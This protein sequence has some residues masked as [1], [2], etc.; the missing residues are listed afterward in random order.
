M[1]QQKSRVTFGGVYQKYG[2]WIILAV[3][4]FIFAMLSSNFFQGDNRFFTPDNLLSVGRQVSFIGIAAVGGT[5]LMISGGID[6]STGSMV[7]LAGVLSTMMIVEANM[8][9]ALAIIITVVVGFAFGSVSGIAYTKWKVSPMIATLAMQTILKGISYLITNAKPVRGFGD[10]FKFLGQGYIGGF[11]PVPLAIMIAVF[12]FGWW[13][14]NRTYVGR[15]IYAIG[16]NS[17]AAR[18]S[19]ININKL[20]IIVFA[21]SG[22]FAAFAGV[23][24]AARLGS[25]QPSS[26]ISDF[27]MEVITAV[28]LGGVSIAGGSGKIGSVVA[29]VLIMGIL[30]NGMV[31]LSLSEYWQWVIKGL[32]LM[33]AVA[34]SNLQVGGGGGRKAKAKLAK[35]ASSG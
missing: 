14:L 5:F 18:L 28:V 33:F 4:I 9:I 7:S 15:H 19:G 16:G 35:E 22:M 32:V 24:M 17:E 13:L 8:P 12:V 20:S 34:A 27:A 21:F 25:G 31:M 3:E 29:G 2:V 6:I 26:G 30:A 23:L 11:F 10:D 1:E